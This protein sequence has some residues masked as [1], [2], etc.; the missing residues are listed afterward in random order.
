[1]VAAGILLGVNIVVRDE[2]T[3]DDDFPIREPKTSRGWPL[4]Y[5]TKTSMPPDLISHIDP[6][7]HL[8]PV[9]VNLKRGSKSK[10]KKFS[11]SET[12]VP[13]NLAMN[14][15]ASVVILCLIAAIMERLTKSIVNDSRSGSV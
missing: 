11:P 2:S 3:S 9:I 4:H 15:G 6:V 8:Q 10:F 14:I 1:M 12:F 5:Y 7:V 13:A